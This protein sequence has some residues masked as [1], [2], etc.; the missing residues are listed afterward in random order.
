VEAACK[1]VV[2]R[3]PKQT[4]A[5]WRVR[6]VE[7]MASLCCVLYGERWEAYRKKAIG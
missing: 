5:R 4:G 7:R 6:R 2:G 1:T 3:R